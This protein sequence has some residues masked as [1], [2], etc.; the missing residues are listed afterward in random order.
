MSLKKTKRYINSDD[1]ASYL[2]AD[3]N[4]PD[5][6]E[7]EGEQWESEESER[8]KINVNELLNQSSNGNKDFRSIELVGADLQKT[9]LSEANFDGAKLISSNFSNANL[10]GSKFFEADLRDVNFTKANLNQ[11]DL[12]WT[13][14]RRANLRRANLSFAN[15]IDSQLFMANFCEANLSGCD[16]S[17]SN[18]SGADCNRVNLSEADLLKAHLIST[19][20]SLAN[21]YRAKF[22]EADLNKANFRRADLRRAD[23]TRVQALSTDFTGAHLTGAC[24]EDWNI[25]SDTKLDGVICKYVYL[26]QNQNER[27]PSSGEFSP[28]EFTK[29][30]Q[31]LLDTIDFIFRDGVDW[32]AFAYAFEVTKNECE[33]A[34]L[35]IQSLENKNDGILVVRLRVSPKAD[36]TTIH[37]VFMQGY[38]FASNFLD[39]KYK[40][41]LSS[42]ET[43]INE[44][45]SLIRQ[46]SE[47]RKLMAEAPKYDMRGS[48]FG[49]FVD[50][51]QS[52]SRQQSVQHNYTLEKKQN[53][54]EAANEI[55]RLL[56]QL[57]ATH[58]KATET[59]K[60]SFVTAAIAPTLKKRA[61][62]AL[63]AGG[64]AAIEELLDNPYVNIAMAIIE[65]W[66]EN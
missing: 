3:E 26:K 60:K 22:I 4:L 63:Q 28:G 39:A 18:L 35:A 53:L 40:E 66:K 10:A 19:D 59:E 7:I 13:D 5:T 45:I 23:L 38:K 46:Q 8:R 21:L 14:L 65:E 49:N 33:G 50:T 44:L 17:L 29:L 1:L 61:V 11:A 48:N 51:A 16:L 25:N 30:F 9:E 54:A 55:Q 2:T 52:G 6:D 58:P 43:Q 64:K 56:I 42:K 57:E 34:N 12:S 36:K 41:E 31:K 27:R 32:K 20:L 47:V 24:L 15:F 62:S 37:G